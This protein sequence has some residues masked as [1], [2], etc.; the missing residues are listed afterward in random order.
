ME[1]APK[2]GALF[3]C[4]D[5]LGWRR[6][7]VGLERLEEVGTEMSTNLARLRLKFGGGTPTQ[8]TPVAEG[9]RKKRSDYLGD[10]MRINLRVKST[11]ARDLQ[12]LKMAGLIE[13]NGF[14]ERVIEEA[15]AHKMREARAEIGAS[16]WEVIVRC[17]E[18]KNTLDR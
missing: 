2:L 10:R 4:P 12:V 17:A 7:Q 14:C 13:K 15:V 16:A 11:L 3:F 9:L 8:E 5:V 1:R 6:Q 18:R